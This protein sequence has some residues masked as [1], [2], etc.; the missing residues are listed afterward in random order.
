MKQL[1]LT[2]LIVTF[3]LSCKKEDTTT[4]TTTTP[5][6][7]TTKTIDTIQTSI[8]KYGA[9]VKDIDGNKYKTVIIGKQEWMGENL[10]VSKNNDG[11][12]IPNI[13]DYSKWGYNTTGAWCHYN[14][15]ASFNEKYG[16]FYNKYALSEISNGNKNVCPSGWHVPTEGE[17]T[18]LTE[19]L[20][21]SSIAGGKMKEVGTN[22]WKSPNNDASNTSLFSALPGG[23]RDFTGNYYLINYN[24]VWWTSSE[25]SNSQA[26][27]I[28]LYSYNGKASIGKTSNG[29]YNKVDGMSIRCIKD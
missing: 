24:G 20:G 8:V 9:G 3:L 25:Q 19:F 10:K 5:N 13:S 26:W 2:L 29:E 22:S 15:D 27:A 21:G 23:R 28:T 17:W 7:T 18:I 14:N 1:L 11:T 12:D 6:T 4:T 16:K